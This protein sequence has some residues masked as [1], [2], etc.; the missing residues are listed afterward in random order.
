[1][2]RVFWHE[3]LQSALDKMAHL[4]VDELPV[5]REDNPDKIVGLLSKRDIISHYHRRITT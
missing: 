3:S 4:N 5:A 1:V 2:V